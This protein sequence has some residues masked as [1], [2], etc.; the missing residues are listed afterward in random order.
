MVYH[1]GCAALTRGAV[2]LSA[3]C[4]SGLENSTRPLV[5]TSA[6]SC[7][8]SKNFDISSENQIFSHIC[9]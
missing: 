7:R 8:A 4:D 1:D 5:F 2:G 6:S 9:Q 3:A